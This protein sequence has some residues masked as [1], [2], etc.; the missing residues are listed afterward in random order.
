MSS[1]NRKPVDVDFIKY[2]EIAIEKIRSGEMYWCAISMKFM[3]GGTVAL[4]T[5]DAPKRP[6]GM[7]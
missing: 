3:D 6:R 7:S 4:H 1:L 5:K 2:L